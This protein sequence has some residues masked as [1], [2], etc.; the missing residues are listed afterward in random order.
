L[1][2]FTADHA[3]Q[4]V[5]RIY[6][7]TTGMYAIPIAFYNPSDSLFKGIDSTVAQQ[8]DIMPTVLHYLGYHKP[9]FAFGESLLDSCATH[10]AISFVNGIYQLIEDE[11]VM[12]FDG[13]KVISFYHINQQD[14]K[15]GVDAPGRIS[16][17]KLSEKYENMENTLK[18]ILQTYTYCLIN[19]KTTQ[20]HGKVQ[21]KI[22]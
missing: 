11:Y 14:K 17:P 3:A 18:A 7:S 8:L 20:S 13:D 19:N 5:E 1:F 16:D 22:D 10:R 2:V 21:K 15:N 12:L 9:F 4:A 6:N